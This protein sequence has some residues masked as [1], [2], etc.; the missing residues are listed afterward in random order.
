MF[1]L[2]LLPESCGVGEISVLKTKCARY[3]VKTISG[4]LR[5]DRYQCCSCEPSLPPL[6]DT[7]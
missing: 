7:A 6:I 4:N 2:I 5:Q 3:S 1:R